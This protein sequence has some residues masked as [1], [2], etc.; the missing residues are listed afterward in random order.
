M[1]RKGKKKLEA[2]RIKATSISLE[3]FKPATM[4][5]CIS[6][7]AIA[8]V[9]LKHA[10]CFNRSEVLNPASRWIL[11]LGHDWK[12]W[13]LVRSGDTPHQVARTGSHRSLIKNSRF[14][15]SSG[16]SIHITG[17]P[18]MSRNASSIMPRNL[19]RGARRLTGTGPSITH[20]IGIV[21][22]LSTVF[23]EVT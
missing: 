1:F 7:P 22:I 13:I 19:Q 9:P 15:I 16:I 4:E 11:P 17:G 5:N 12:P 3:K 18:G 6:P 23:D 2:I 8:I 20:M 10:Q 14:R 21:S